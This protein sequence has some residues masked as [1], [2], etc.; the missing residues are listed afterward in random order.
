MKDEHYKRMIDMLTEAT[1]EKKFE[2]TEGSNPLESYSTEVGGCRIKIWSDYDFQTEDTSYMISLANPDGRVFVTY[3]YS[4]QEEP[5]EFKCLEDLYNA[6]RDAVYRISESE[7]L[8][9][10]DLQSIINSGD[11]PAF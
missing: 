2:W 4:E 11:A 7:K 6:I 1:K 8:I 5:T 9:L 10:D 3:S